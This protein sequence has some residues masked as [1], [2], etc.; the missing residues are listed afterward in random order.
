MKP[1]ALIEGSP[2]GIFRTTVCEV[3]V[4]LLL[5]GH[6]TPLQSQAR[7]SLVPG[8]GLLTLWKDT[9]APH[10]LLRP[11]RLAH[12]NARNGQMLP[13]LV[14][15]LSQ[16]QLVW[17]EEGKGA[18]LLVRSRRKGPRRSSPVRSFMCKPDPSEILLG[19][20]LT[21]HFLLPQEGVL[22]HW[23][24]HS[25]RSRVRLTFLCSILGLLASRHLAGITKSGKLCWAACL[26]LS[27]E[28]ALLGGAGSAE[29]AFLPCLSSQ[30]LPVS[31]TRDGLWAKRICWEQSLRLCNLIVYAC[32]VGVA[33][34]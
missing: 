6:E 4:L 16:G 25:F 9:A 19:A 22:G 5:G 14:F 33:G 32:V 17:E 8:P 2:H 3:W 21:P 7:L 29:L 10:A 12:Q 31:L 18:L 13:R 27:S 23:W 28:D 26:L 15:G 11:L 20:A 24:G 30:A 1:W 34:N